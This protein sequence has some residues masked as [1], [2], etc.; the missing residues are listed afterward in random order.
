ML[1]ARLWVRPYE[2]ARCFNIV[3]QIHGPAAGPEWRSNSYRAV[4]VVGPSATGLSRVT[5]PRVKRLP[6]R[7][8]RLNA[9]SGKKESSQATSHWWSDGSRFQVGEVSAKEVSRVPAASP[10]AHLV[11]PGMAS[12]SENGVKEA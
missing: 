1:C 6:A 4:G 9:K 11:P 3:R 8:Q 10:H 12:G 5:S 2:W 7:V